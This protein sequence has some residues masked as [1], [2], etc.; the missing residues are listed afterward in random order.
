[1]TGCGG[2]N[3]PVGQEDNAG[4]SAATFACRQQPATWR[5]YW[6]PHVGATGV[7]PL[8]RPA[9]AHPRVL[10]RHSSAVSV[11]NPCGGGCSRPADYSPDYSYPSLREQCGAGISPCAAARPDSG[12]HILPP[13]SAGQP[14]RVGPPGASGL[15]SCPP[16]HVAGTTGPHSAPGTAARH[17]PVPRRCFAHVSVHAGW[18]G[19]CMTHQLRWCSSRDIMRAG[20]W[21]EK[22]LMWKTYI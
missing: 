1:M 3:C 7:W 15:S 20:T 11:T 18:C 9:V 5:T 19:A 17:R 14:K 10:H 21:C 16:P 12:Q 6:P 13:P 22:G 4:R 8:P 2:W